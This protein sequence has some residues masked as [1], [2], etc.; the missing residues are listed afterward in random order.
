[1]W[2]LAGVGWYSRYPQPP[3]GGL[4]VGA[5]LGRRWR[6]AV[7]RRQRLPPVPPPHSA[8]VRHTRQPGFPLTAAAVGAL[9]S[10]GATTYRRA[11]TGRQRG[12]ISVRVC[13]R[14][15]EAVCACTYYIYVHAHIYIHIGTYIHVLVCVRVCVS[16][17]VRARVCVFV[18]LIETERGR[19][20][21]NTCLYVRVCV[22]V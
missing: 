7:R 11:R 4:G 10:G 15:E 12:R 3:S 19:E 1:M 17:C 2:V 13:A 20:S 16:Q 9:P 21:G 22:F 5:A 8:R 18:C 6:C 14:T